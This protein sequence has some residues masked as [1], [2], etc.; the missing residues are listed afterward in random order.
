ME[1]VAA[2]RVV[3]PDCGADIPGD[4]CCWYCENEPLEG[5]PYTGSYGVLMDLDK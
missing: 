1:V 3:C 5:W 2:G 4:G